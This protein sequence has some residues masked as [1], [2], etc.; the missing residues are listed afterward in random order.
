MFPDAED[1]QTG[2]VGQLNLLQQMMHSFDGAKG[3]TGDRIWNCCCEAV[4]TNLQLCGSLYPHARLAD[5]A[6]GCFD[7]AIVSDSSC[8]VSGSFLLPRKGSCAVKL[9]HLPRPESSLVS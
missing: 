6:F 3:D 8:R 2:L 1:V 7:V 9:D 5:Y 4:D